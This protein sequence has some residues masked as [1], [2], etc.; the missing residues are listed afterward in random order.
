MGKQRG[1]QDTW[2]DSSFEANNNPLISSYIYVSIYGFYIYLFCEGRGTYTTQ[3]ALWRSR[4][5]WGLFLTPRWFWDSTQRD[6]HRERQTRQ[7]TLLPVECVP[8]PWG[9]YS[10]T[11]AGPKLPSVPLPQFLKVRDYMWATVLSEDSFLNYIPYSVLLGSPF[12]EPQSACQCGQWNFISLFYICSLGFVF[13][14]IGFLFWD[15]LRCSPRCPT[16]AWAHSSLLVLSYRRV[17]P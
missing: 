10:V 4:T 3:H 11:Q 17:P 6:R 1:G 5:I 14:F 2:W 13:V 8:S 16:V 9:S 12:V 7:Q 15:S